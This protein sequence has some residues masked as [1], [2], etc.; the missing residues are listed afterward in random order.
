MFLNYPWTLGVPPLPLECIAELLRMIT[1]NV[2]SVENSPY[3]LWSY[4]RYACKPTRNTCAFS[5]ITN[6]LAINSDNSALVHKLLS[7]G[8]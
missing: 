1:P 8:L 7:L 2:L 6:M 3:E 5:K 4:Y